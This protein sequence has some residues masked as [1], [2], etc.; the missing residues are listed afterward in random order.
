M[1]ITNRDYEFLNDLANV[2][3]LNSQRITRLY[4]NYKVTMR[5]M[6]LLTDHGF[7]EII[8]NTKN[9]YKISRKC[10]SF[11]SKPYKKPSKTDKL[12]HFL[13]CAD[14][15]FFIKSTHNIDNFLLEQQIKFKYQGKP[16]SFRPD[17]LSQIDGRWYMIEIDLSNKRFEEKIK[18]WETYYLSNEF[19]KLFDKFPPIMIIGNNIEK[20]KSIIQTNQSINFNYF[21]KSYQEVLN[22]EYKYMYRHDK[23]PYNAI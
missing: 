18:R 8:Q 12:S 10:S 4:G 22:W 13:A 9:I 6:K 5:R 3:Y 7:L 23:T 19:I 16:Y 11:L 17:I 14:F 15:Y 21:F 2:G 20:V 1:Q